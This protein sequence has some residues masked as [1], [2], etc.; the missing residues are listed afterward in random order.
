MSTPA[1]LAL[2]CLLVLA[3][4]AVLA[5]P[6]LSLCYNKDG[7]YPWTDPHRPGLSLRM[8]Q[9]VGARLGME[10]RLT[11]MA[12]QRCLT[13]VKARHFD[14]ALAASYKQER[15]EFGRY[16]ALENGRVNPAKRLFVEQHV[17]VRRKGSQ[18]AWDGKTVQPSTARIAAPSQ[19]S[20][21]QTLRALGL[22]VDDGTKSS[23]AT[24]RK[25]LLQRADAAIL[26]SHGAQFEM[27]RF[28]ELADKLEIASESI[29]ERVYY[30]MLGYSVDDA[31]AR[32]IW[33]ACEYVR[34]SPEYAAAQRA[35][36]SGQ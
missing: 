21:V 2:V 30:L 35:F 32:R 18:V 22:T 31:L 24:L 8:A 6:V 10:T 12:W 23:E 13:E 16:P 5:A 11:G 36:Y 26:L 27:G 29:E 33:D 19:T 7:S 4:P 28:A 1:R 9:L 34:D 3:A 20:I 14:G 17:L 25:V 15:L